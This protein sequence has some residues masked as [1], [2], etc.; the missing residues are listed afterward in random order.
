MAAMQEVEINEVPPNELDEVPEALTAPEAAPKR[1]KKMFL[2]RVFMAELLVTFL[3]LFSVMAMGV[4]LSK[5]NK[6][7]T[8]VESAIVTGFCAVA[9]IYSF[10]DVSGAHFNPA[11][12]FATMVT[13]K[14]SIK[15][16]LCY[17]AAQLLAS[18]LATFWIGCLFN[19]DQIESLNVMPNDQGTL[20]FQ[21]FLMETTLTFILCYV[22]FATAFSTID[23]S[24]VE[25][26]KVLSDKKIASVKTKDLT[27]YNVSGNSK[28]GFAGIAIGFTLGFLT[29]I[30][31]SVSGGAFNPARVFGPAVCTGYIFTKG[32]L[33]L[34]WVGDFC[35]AAMAGVL[36]H[37]FATVQRFEKEG[38]TA[39]KLATAFVPRELTRVVAPGSK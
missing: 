13:R 31:G 37:F 35:G 2:F 7:P 34:Y 28:A 4:N 23:T 10:A 15:K 19:F 3:F 39:G 16:G 9:M 20:L 14:T 27:V 26:T 38:V 11:V 33:W 8:G 32:S 5:A 24:N 25:L 17:I 1:E 22:I 29:M 30:G 18:V 21:A 12:T 36:Q 6:S